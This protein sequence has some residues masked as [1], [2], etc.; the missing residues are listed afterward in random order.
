ME[1]SFQCNENRTVYKNSGVAPQTINIAI[2]E[3]CGGNSRVTVFD[4]HHN[5][6]GET[7]FRSPGGAVTLTVYPNQEV[8]V[9][10]D[11]GSDLHGCKYAIVF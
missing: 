11:G 6:I 4:S 1:Y 9:F 5:A 2:Q 10:C 3:N 8:E 7:L